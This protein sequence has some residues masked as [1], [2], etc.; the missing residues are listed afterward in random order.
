MSIVLQ[1][2]AVMICKQ[3]VCSQN[4]YSSHYSEGKLYFDG[5]VLMAEHLIQSGKL[6][7]AARLM[8]GAENSGYCN[9]HCKFVLGKLR[10]KEENYAE[11]K[12]F[13]VEVS[14]R[15]QFTCDLIYN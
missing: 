14:F 5:G 15:T 3:F 9:A 2:F 13:C 8:Q 11:S 10:S 7:R 4:I 6:Y 1:T 12:Q